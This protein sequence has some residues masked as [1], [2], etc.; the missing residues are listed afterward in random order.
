MC[1]QTHESCAVRMKKHGH[2]LITDYHLMVF[3]RNKK[4]CV[5]D[6]LS[7]QYLCIDF[8]KRGEISAEFLR[9]RYR[10]MESTL[11]GT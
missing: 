7:K 1:L 5:K 8:L 3:T 10:P 2:E 9:L 11:V 4:H 6:T